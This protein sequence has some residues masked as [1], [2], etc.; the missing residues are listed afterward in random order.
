M[1]RSFI[2]S[3]VGVV[4][5]GSLAG[6]KT[7][8]D[9]KAKYFANGSQTPLR[10]N[11][12]TP[13]GKRDLEIYKYVIR[14]MRARSD[15]LSWGAQADIHATCCPHN[16]NFFLPW[17]RAFIY[18]FEEVARENLRTM[19]ASW[20]TELVATIKNKFGELSATLENIIA[21]FA[22]PYWDWGVADPTIPAE[23]LDQGNKELY[24][25]T[26]SEDAKT[27]KKLNYGQNEYFKPDWLNGV[28]SQ[29][30]FESF[31]GAPSPDFDY[32]SHLQNND[33]IT[34]Q[35][36]AVGVTTLLE[37]TY[38]NHIHSF[39]GGL[40]G[41]KGMISDRSPTDPL[42]WIHHANIDRIWF[43]WAYSQDQNPL[44]H[45]K[46]NLTLQEWLKFPMGNFIDKSG[47]TVTSAVEDVLDPKNAKVAYDT[48][49]PNSI[50]IPT[51]RP[52]ANTPASFGLSAEPQGEM[53]QLPATP[54]VRYAWEVGEG[55]RNAKRTKGVTYDEESQTNIASVANN[56]KTIVFNYNSTDKTKQLILDHLNGKYKTFDM[57]V[58]NLPLPTGLLVRH[59]MKIEFFIKLK[60]TSRQRIGVH[61]FFGHHSGMHGDHSQ[62]KHMANQFLIEKAKINFSLNHLIKK[63]GITASQVE[64]YQ[65]GSNDIEVTAEILYAGNPA[66]ITWSQNDFKNATIDLVT[67]Q[68]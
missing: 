33:N 54:D 41:D 45:S 43:D 12:S 15:K 68:A 22:V 4:G 18:W 31:G 2:K 59:Q 65:T 17:H 21:S 28:L 40:D 7:I 48:I 24:F 62:H 44:P 26:R 27:N 51:M 52:P 6:C 20:Q 42:F 56:K 11:I 61:V 3:T 34:A 47:A 58:G 49:D 1:R 57:R 66:D 46:D 39:V 9:S 50:T 19:D 16:N 13:N 5:A 53:R 30:D 25:E 8:G 14:A 32:R 67:F 64:G 36:T 23:F 63:L 35:R 60:G 55:L 29:S 38:H 10:A 37:S